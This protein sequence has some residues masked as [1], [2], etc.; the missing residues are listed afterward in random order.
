M[1]LRL[2]ERI[3]G[4]LHPNVARTF[5]GLDECDEFP[6]RRDLRADDFRIAKDEFA[7]DDRR[8]ALRLG[9]RSRSVC[10]R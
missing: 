1:G 2:I 5:E 7:I 3:F 8:L 9:Q 10:N 6:V 4:A